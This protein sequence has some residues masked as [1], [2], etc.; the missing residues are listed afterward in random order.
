MNNRLLYLI[1]VLVTAAILGL[2]AV[3]LAIRQKD[4]ESA[5]TLP[6]TFIGRA[7]PDFQGDQL[8]A[9]PLLARDDLA[10][11]EIVIVNFWA[12]WCAPCRAEHPLLERLAREDGITIYGV[13]Y[14]DNPAR[15]LGFLEELGN[16]YAKIIADNSGRTGL[17]W[18]LYGVPETFVI[19][20]SGTVILRHPGPVTEQVFREKIRPALG[21]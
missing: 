19:D 2:A 3:S 16:P 15:A 8:G 21:L 13:N 5:D 12:S 14:K 18:G 4:P 7:A 10:R 11:G 17:N 9:L 1:P 20:G 6:S